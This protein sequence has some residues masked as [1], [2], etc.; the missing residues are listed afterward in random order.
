MIA[1]FCGTL[2]VRRFAAEGRGNWWTVA[3]HVGACAHET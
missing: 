2:L 1:Q 3:W